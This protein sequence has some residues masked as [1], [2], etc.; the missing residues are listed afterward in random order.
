MK[1]LNSIRGAILIVFEDLNA[2]LIYLNNHL[3]KKFLKHKFC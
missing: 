2:M 3:N 1:I